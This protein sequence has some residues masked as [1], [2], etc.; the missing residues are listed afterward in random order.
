MNQNMKSI[1][2]AYAAITKNRDWADVIEKLSLSD[3]FCQVANN[4]P[5]YLYESYSANLLEIVEELKQQDECPDE[6]FKITAQSIVEYNQKRKNTREV[7]ISFANQREDIASNALRYSRESIEKRLR[8]VLSE[9]TSYSTVE[10]KKWMEDILAF[11]EN[12]KDNS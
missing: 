1:L 11:Y 8:S 4:N 10:K 2:E 3:V 9:N 5:H 12:V 7:K 6:I